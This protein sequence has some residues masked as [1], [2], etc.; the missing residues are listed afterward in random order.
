[1]DKKSQTSATGNV[2]ST[3]RSS[4]W[5]K[6]PIVNRNAADRPPAQGS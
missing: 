4:R 1:M 5:D 6:T 2:E 3:P